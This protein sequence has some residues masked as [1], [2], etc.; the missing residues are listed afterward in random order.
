MKKKQERLDKL[1]EIT[2]EKGQQMNG[3]KS[4]EIS[5]INDRCKSN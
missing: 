4:E 2:A 1:M 5:N 3:H